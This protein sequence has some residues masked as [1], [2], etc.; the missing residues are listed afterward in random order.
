MFLMAKTAEKL[1]IGTVFPVWTG[2]GAVGA[3]VV[4]IIFFH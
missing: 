2:I 4:G 3:V 1:L